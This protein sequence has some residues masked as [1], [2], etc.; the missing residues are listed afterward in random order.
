LTLFVASILG[1][2]VFFPSFLIKSSSCSFDES[3]SA[4]TSGHLSFRG[5]V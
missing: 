4:I 5:L 2:K 3:I 1:I